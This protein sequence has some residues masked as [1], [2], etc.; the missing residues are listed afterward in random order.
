MIPCHG[1]RLLVV[2]LGLLQ[3]TNLAVDVAQRIEA[4]RHGPNVSDLFL[5][6]ER[7][8]LTA[9]AALQLTGLPVCQADEVERHGE[10]AAIPNGAL[11]IQRLLEILGGLRE[12]AQVPVRVSDL[13]EADRLIAHVT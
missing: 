3:I 9:Q 5:D 11:H 2:L 1:Q 13:A 10:T 12:V 6:L 7:L 4:A 8:E